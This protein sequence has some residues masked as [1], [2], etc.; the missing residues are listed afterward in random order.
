MVGFGKFVSHDT[1]Y[2][3]EAKWANGVKVS[4]LFPSYLY[5]KIYMPKSTSLLLPLLAR[6]WDF[7]VPLRWQTRRG[8][9][10]RRNK[11][12]GILQI[13]RRFSLEG[14]WVLIYRLI[15]IDNDNA[16]GFASHKILDGKIKTCFVC[17]QILH[18]IAFIYHSQ[19]RFKYKKEFS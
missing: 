10:T 4:F 2:I 17:D 5:F 12:S 16:M 11:W 7:V 3:Y 1:G 6:S 13:R 9:G 8:V 18:W 14:S 15:I 19:Y